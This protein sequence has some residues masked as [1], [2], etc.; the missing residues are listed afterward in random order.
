[1]IAIIDYGMGNLGS[2]KNIL[3][4]VGEENVV[5]SSEPTILKKADKL[6]L[7]GVGSFDA[8]IS[9]LR[10]RGLID[11]IRSAALED[12]KPLL[13][14]CLG[15]QLLGKSSEEG[16]ERGL[17]L[18]PFESVKFNASVTL[19]VPHMGWDYVEI[20]REE[21][22]V[23]NIVDKQRYYFVHSFYAKCEYEENVLM[24][25]EYGVKFASAVINDNI[26]GV[27]FHP[28]K[29]HSFGMRIMENFVREY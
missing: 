17:E 25:T 3:A 13:G 18:I 8:G 10:E 15:M 7:P 22:I 20:C 24:T 2:I 4:Y 29:S 28:E 16:T 14:I 5:I 11:T 23:K 12:R 6:I 9:N 1:M 26:I 19:K 21:P 27:Q